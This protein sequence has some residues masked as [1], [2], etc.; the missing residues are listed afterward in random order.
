VRKVRTAQGTVLDNVQAE[1][2]DGKCNRKIPPEEKDE[3]GRMKDESDHW[4]RVCLV[5]AVVRFI[6]HPSEFILLFR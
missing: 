2:S 1:Q 4:Y 6:L 3:G 5:P